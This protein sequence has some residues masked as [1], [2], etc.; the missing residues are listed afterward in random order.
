MED[1][2]LIIKSVIVGVNTMKLIHCADLHLDSSF[3][4]HFTVGQ[5]RERNM[6]LLN[7][8]QRLVEYG[9]NIGVAGIL[10]A[11]DMFDSNQ[12]TAITRNT[13]LELIRSYPEISFFY[14]EGNHDAKSY[15]KQSSQLPENLFLFGENWRTYQLGEVAISGAELT[16]ENG[17]FLGET[18]RLQ[19]EQTNIV[20][21]HG[22]VTEYQIANG[23]YILPL[24]SFRRKGIDYMALG[25]IHS[26]EKERLDSRGIYCYSGCL[27]G[28]GFDECGEK[29]FILLDISEDTGE[30]E[31]TFIPFAKRRMYQL[32]V[33]I[34]DCMTSLEMSRKIREAISING[35]K[36][37]DC[38][39]IKLTGR[40]NVMCEKN[41]LFLKKE[42]GENFYFI[43]I[44]D[45][46]QFAVDYAEFIAEESL[47]GEFV[48]IVQEGE[49]SEEEKAEIIQC[50]FMALSGEE[51]TG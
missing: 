17:G 33:E 25:H 44:V 2:F 13:V 34:S 39:L 31:T 49:L 26:Y 48:R 43:E 46:T 19:E 6:E 8:F 9:Q 22:M 51:L 1:N 47:R 12:V 10:I 37:E 7:N 3:Y 35:I 29:G 28:R 15:I 32:P 42:Y 16:G 27:E 24:S 18:L 36:E 5:A 20:M 11:G 23:E 4:T 50:G 45:E 41:L 30:V 21:L 40:L 38:V 14:L